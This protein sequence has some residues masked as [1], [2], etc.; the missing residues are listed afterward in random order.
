V[1]L[2]TEGSATPLVSIITPT[3]NRNQFLPLIFDSVNSQDWP[4][5]EWLVDDDSEEPSPFLNDLKNERVFY[6]HNASRRSV[7]TK[8]NALISNARGTYIVHFD[9]DD[10]YAPT[11]VS[12]MIAALQ[13]AMVDIVKLGAYYVYHQ[14]DP[15]LY[16]WDLTRESHIHYVCLPD[17][18]LQYS[19]S[20]DSHRKE[21]KRHVLG[22]GF[23]YVYK[24]SVWEAHHFPDRDF[25]EDLAFA[26]SVLT[27]HKMQLHQ[28]ERGI[29]LHII[30]RGNLSGCL[31]QYALP[32]FLI[33]SIFPSIGA[34]IRESTS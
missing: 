15:R 11:Y 13:T 9:D 24:K 31:P 28:D 5:L 6:T 4:H 34:Y 25:G 26:R 20:A 27:D 19:I 32:P 21:M 22:Y 30:H 12:T 33:E 14:Q 10:Y 29:C 8:R 3:R 23:S 18:P 7:G 16:Y 2:S 17:Y 1:T